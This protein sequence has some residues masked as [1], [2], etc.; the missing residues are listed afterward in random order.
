MINCVYF[1]VVGRYRDNICYENHYFSRLKVRKSDTN[2]TNMD[3]STKIYGF[4][5]S[6]TIVLSD[7]NSTVA[8]GK[9]TSFQKVVGSLDDANNFNISLKSVI[10]TSTRDSCEG[11]SK[12]L[13]A[14]YDSWMDEHHHHSGAAR[15]QQ[16]VHDLKVQFV[17]YMC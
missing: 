12:V 3:I 14:N 4:D 11:P 6:N 17:F 13:Q 9:N 16:T 5:L 7:D 1:V 8:F 2:T 10:E 15:F